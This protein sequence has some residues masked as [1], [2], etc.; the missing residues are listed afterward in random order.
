MGEKGSQ[1]L[2]FIFFIWGVNILKYDK[3]AVLLKIAVLLRQ[4]CFLESCQVHLK[5]LCENN[6]LQL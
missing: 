1:H 5:I 2:L 3:K 6:V 4:L